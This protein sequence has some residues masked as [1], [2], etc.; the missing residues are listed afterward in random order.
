LLRC[1]S[2][3]FAAEEEDEDEADVLDALLLLTSSAKGSAKGS[4]MASRGVE[5]VEE[6]WTEAE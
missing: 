5:G 3:S 2:L 1:T 4:A 6:G